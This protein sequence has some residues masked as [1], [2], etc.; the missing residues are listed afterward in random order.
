GDRPAR[1]DRPTREEH[2]PREERPAREDRRPQS[3]EARREEFRRERR[4][5]REA[6]PTPRGFGDAVPAFM[7]VAIPRPRRDAAAEGPSG[8]AEPEAA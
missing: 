3:Y 6:G 4:E 8:E 7:L 1:E 2:A 5:D